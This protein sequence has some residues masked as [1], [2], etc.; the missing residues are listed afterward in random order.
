[1]TM[2]CGPSME[3]G[4][5]KWDTKTELRTR[6]KVSLKLDSGHQL[7]TAGKTPLATATLAPDGKTLDIIIRMD[8]IAALEI[9]EENS[10]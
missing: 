6:C 2:E 10:I 4:E 5:H 1:M 9:N 8:R 7:F 3:I